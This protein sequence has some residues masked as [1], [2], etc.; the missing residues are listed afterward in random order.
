M[1]QKIE[2]GWKSIVCPDWKE[3]AMIMCEWDIL[4]E[5]GSI[6]QRTLKQID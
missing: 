5:K 2:R 3:K 6:L 4:S 1:E